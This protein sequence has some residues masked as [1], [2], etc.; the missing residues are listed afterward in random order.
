V[1]GWVGCEVEGA[2][3]EEAVC[4]LRGG[5]EHPPGSR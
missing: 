1:G 4:L 3:G 2:G 5:R